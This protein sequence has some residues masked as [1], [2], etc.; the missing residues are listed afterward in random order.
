MKN[1]SG[2]SRQI[3]IAILALLFC[4]PSQFSK[5]QAVECEPCNFTPLFPETVCA[6]DISFIEIG[7]D[8]NQPIQG[9]LQPLYDAFYNALGQNFDVT[10]LISLGLSTQYNNELLCPGE[11][12]TLDYSAIDIKEILQDFDVSDIVDT[13]TIVNNLNFGDGDEFFLFMDA[14]GIDLPVIGGNIEGLCGGDEVCEAL[15]PDIDFTLIDLKDAIDV[16]LYDLI[17][18]ALN[19]VIDSI[20]DPIIDGIQ[21]IVGEVFNL[22][23]GSNLDIFVD[24]DGDGNFDTQ[25]LDTEDL[26]FSIDFDDPNLGLV[27][28]G[29]AEAPVNLTEDGNIT[30]RILLNGMSD[31][32]VACPCPTQETFLFGIDVDIPVVGIDVGISCDFNYYFANFFDL[33]IPVNVDEE[34]PAFTTSPQDMTVECNGLGNASDL[35]TWLDNNGNAVATD[36]CDFSWETPV[37][38]SETDLC[39]PENIYNYEFCATDAAGNQSC[40]T[41][42]FIIEDNTP[43]TISG[44]RDITVDCDLEGANNIDDLFG[45]LASNGGATASDICSNIQWSNDFNTANFESGCITNEDVTVN[46]TATDECGNS[47]SVSLS[48]SVFDNIAP[49]F[50]NCPRPDIVENAET[51][52]CDAYVNFSPPIAFD[53]CSD[54]VIN[55]LSPINPNT[56]VAYESGDRF[57]VGTTIMTYEAVDACGNTTICKFKVIVNDYWDEPVIGCVDDITAY[58]DDWEC[59]AEVDVP[60]PSVTDVC[61][62]LVMTTYQIVFEGDVLETGLVNP[63]EDDAVTFDFPVGKSTVNFCTQDQPLLLITEVTQDMDNVCGGA[64]PAF[65][66]PEDITTDDCIEITNFGPVPYDL[67]CLVIDRCLPDG[68]VESFTVPEGTIVD[69]GGTLVLCYGDYLEEA[70][71]LEGNILN[72]PSFEDAAFN[73]L[74]DSPNWT[75]FGAVFGIDGSIIPPVQDGTWYL[76]MFGG[77]SGIFQEHPVNPGDQV[78]ASVYVE[79]ASFDPMLPGCS[80]FISVEYYDAGNQQ[81]SFTLSNILDD[82]LPLNT[83]TQISINDIVPPGAV[84]ARFVVLLQCTAGGAGFFDNAQ[85]EII[86]RACNDLI[87]CGEEVL[88]N[89]S[90]ESNNGHDTPFYPGGGPDGEWFSFNTLGCFNGDVF[91]IQSGLTPLGVAQDGDFF[92]KMFCFAGTFQDYPVVSGDQVQ[93]SVYVKNG[94]DEFI[95]P[96]CEGVLKIEFLNA[97]K[98]IIGV[99]EEKVGSDLPVGIWTLMTVEGIAPANAAF[100]RIVLIADCGGGGV[101]LFDNA[102]MVICEPVPIQ[103]DENVYLLGSNVDL[104]P[105]DEAT[106]KIYYGDN[107]IDEMTM[108]EEALG[109]MTRVAVKDTDTDEDWVFAGVCNPITIGQYN[110]GFPDPVKS[111]V[112]NADGSIFVASLQSIPKHSDECPVMVTVS[113]NEAPLCKE[114]T[115]NVSGQGGFSVDAVV[116]NEFSLALA[117]CLAKDVTVNIT[118]DVFDARSIILF[119]PAGTEIELLIDDTFDGSLTATLQEDLYSEKVGGTWLLEV[120]TAKDEIGAFGLTWSLEVECL[121]DWEMDDV[122]LSNDPELCTRTFTWIHPFA[123][124]NCRDVTISVD[125]EFTPFN[126]LGPEPVIPEDGVLEGYG[127]YEVTEIFSVGYTKVTY[128]LI[129]QYGNE[130]ECSFVVKVNDDEI[131]IIICPE[132]IVVNLDPGECRRSVCYLDQVFRDDNCGVKMIMGTPPNCSE[133]EIGTTVVDVTVTDIHGNTNTCAIDI[134][135]NEFIPESDELACNDHINLTLGEDCMAPLT[136]DM[137]LEGN[138]YRCY[139]K[140]CVEI[141]D[142]EGNIVVESTPF[143]DLEFYFG[144]EHLNQIFTIKIIDCLGEG[145]SCWGTV[146]VEE[147]HVPDIM[148]APDV[149][150]Y[151]SMS[152]DPED[153]GYPKLLTCE[154]FADGFTFEDEVENFDNCNDPRSII[155][156]TWTF[157]DNQG[158]IVTCPQ[159]ITVIPVDLTKVKAPA[160]IDVDK[161]LECGDVEDYPYLLEPEYTGYPMIDGYELPKVNTCR[162]AYSYW[163]KSLSSCTGDYA[164]TRTWEIIDLCLP[165]G[166]N[167]PVI[168]TQL[169]KVFDTEPPIIVGCPGDITISTAPYECSASLDLPLPA[170]IYDRCSDGYLDA[171]ILT[172]DVELDIYYDGS[173]KVSSI[174]VEGL[175]RG[176]HTIV[177]TVTDE[178]GNSKTCLFDITVIDAIAP[179]A[180]A[181]EHTVVSLTN[182]GDGEYG[183]AKLFAESLDDGSHDICTDV[184]FEVRRDDGSPSCDNHGEIFDIE[185]AS[186]WNNN[187]TYDNTGHPND[188]P[189]DTDGGEFVKFCCEDLFADGDGDGEAD[190]LVKVWLRVWDDGDGNG[191]FGTRGDNFSE[192]WVYVQIQDKFDPVIYCPPDVTLEC[193]QDPLDLY[194]TG[195]G[196]AQG[197]CSDVPVIFEDEDLRDDCGVGRIYRTW[198][199]DSDGD[200]YWSP[201]EV[202]CNPPQIIDNLIS[203]PFDIDNIYWPVNYDDTDL[204]DQ[205]S[206]ECLPGDTGEPSWDELNCTLVGATLESDTFFFEDDACYKILNHWTIIDWCQ[207][208]PNID[209]EFGI[210]QRTQVIKVIDESAPEFDSCGDVD[211]KATDDCIAT[212]PYDFIDGSRNELSMVATDNGDCPSAWLKWEVCLDIWGDGYCEYL[213]TSNKAEADASLLDNVYYLPASAS[214]QK[215][216]I[217]Y[218]NPADPFDPSIFSLDYG[219]HK[220]IWTVNDGCGNVQSCSSYINVVDLKPPTPICISNLATAVMNESGSVDIWAIDFDKGSFDNCTRLED[221]TISFSGTDYVPSYTIDCSD[222]TDNGSTQ[223]FDFEMWVWDASGNRDYCS[224]QLRVDDNLGVCGGNAGMAMI[225]GQLQTEYGDMIEN[226]EIELNSAYP[227]Y[228]VTQM[229]TDN[230]SYAFDNNPMLQHYE[231]SGEKNDDY[232]NGVSTLDMVLIQLHVLG[233]ELL[234]SPYKI[235]A[236][237]VNADEKVSA[238][239]LVQLRKLILGVYEEL[240]NN[241]SWRFIDIGQS[242]E[243]SFH[244]WPLQEVLSIEGLYHDMMSEDFI[245]VKIGDVNGSA[246]ANNLISTEVRTQ[247]SLTLVAN[248]SNFQSGDE[249]RIEVSSEEF[250]EIYGYQFTLE[251][252]GLIYMG[253]EP[254]ALSVTHDNIGV[255]EGRITTSWHTNQPISTDEVLFTLVFTAVS[256]GLISQT[257]EVNSSITRAESYVANAMNVQSID[258]E[259]LADEVIIEGFKYTLYQNEPN[260]FSESTI[261]G[262]EL[263]AADHAS[264]T[265]YDVAG[266]VIK[267][268]K[269]AFEKGY[270]EVSIERSE[271]GAAGLYYYQ[272]DSGTFS[273]SKK[274]IIIR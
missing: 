257:L 173:G 213:Y 226:V 147:K 87:T 8:L 245:G 247:G 196:S 46:F 241:D 101:V 172:E 125:Y 15:L 157:D 260:P 111:G 45:W 85:M 59:S 121:V 3:K 21:T 84:T 63:F 17:E 78:L 185:S 215:V 180:V 97:N 221:L 96:G 170:N 95:A 44:G 14:L 133:F 236:A 70:C 152:I 29:S 249:V 10:G 104:E 251:H 268:F 202:R 23:G 272:L 80:A 192:A 100:A 190:G 200:G 153:L 67:S 31:T 209:E 250:T 81:I 5:A 64:P 66:I 51:D 93:A 266:Q 194:L 252:Q 50:E 90:F 12:I 86:P 168:R 92:L 2:V 126:D 216:E 39:T 43:P 107:D 20:I 109:G 174:F 273:E 203:D 218:D 197:T 160:D 204:P 144:T 127:G 128:T 181:D 55:N 32:D 48:F 186:L 207:Y 217:P 140:Y 102:S 182:S 62:D 68:G 131:P 76:K 258:L 206:F 224:V 232:P 130:G 72:S 199:V 134:I 9:A 179:I 150:I 6:V 243:N 53:N 122:T 246:A 211:L 201:G 142:Q 108:S 184:Y 259:F 56:G 143:Y 183:T 33:V 169:I 162:I 265:L 1:L 239:D 223:I 98:G 42:S 244:P 188:S 233:I 110:P 16:D 40:R 82:S 65:N 231:V 99:H 235:I 195:H 151:C 54:V 116:C 74:Y 34:G 267:I 208:K 83:W 159:I 132:E 129:D 238:L 135:V 47:S 234:D 256:D 263:P 139:E 26:D 120:V 187:I 141:S 155:T 18:D 89:K 136:A 69:P 230:G 118:G 88:S 262:F 264:I 117:D 57:P 248:E 113:D 94:P 124:D 242:F 149:T 58:N 171:E 210:W 35:Q 145:N 75:R 105:G 138:I 271:L 28:T 36:D 253:V 154:P 158:H 164:I 37:F 254:G 115:N 19:G 13:E 119:S 227:E 148:C 61:E 60:Y 73:F 219:V 161:A 4:I 52:H 178:C 163:D 225:A 166:P 212:V 176:T 261:I 22:N 228:P 165:Q 25:I 114:L 214:G 274:M 106:Y 123:V 156:R 191:I 79:N 24:S 27:E 193:G 167:N 175:E 269:G 91:A 189:F 237:D 11:T 220:V 30:A 38:L 222:L 240:P 7:L 270:N 103:L 112:T 77:N 205:P 255:F 41:A 198:F 146:L 137:I 49:V 177:Y 71:E 229:T